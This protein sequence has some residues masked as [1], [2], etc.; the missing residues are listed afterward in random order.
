ML[1]TKLKASEEK[2][3]K[4]ELE[5]ANLKR[6]LHRSEETRKQIEAEMNLI[7]KT[8]GDTILGLREHL[9]EAKDRWVRDQQKMHREVESSLRNH[10]K[11]Q[12]E[13]N[14]T[15][16]TLEELQKAMKSKDRLLQQRERQIA[17]LL[18]A[19]RTL[20]NGLDE[21]QSLPKHSSSAEDSDDEL[22]LPGAVVLNNSCHFQAMHQTDLM[23]VISSLD[24][25]NFD[26]S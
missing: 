6:E 23:Q 7:L 25:G 8:K 5:N 11:M 14:H 17:G 24:K 15:K 18:E 21:L 13:L 1:K 9:Q 20:G 3:L 12:Q 19:N 10:H 4:Q 16:S 22:I 26:F 2:V